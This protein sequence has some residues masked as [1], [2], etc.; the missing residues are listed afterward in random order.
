MSG[1]A[2]SNSQVGLAHATGHALGA[3]FH[4]PHGVAVGISNPYVVQFSSR[5]AADRYSDIACVIGIREES[6]QK[7]TEMLVGSI[8]RLMAHLKTPLSLHEAG[9][10]QSAFDDNVGSLI[11]QTN[12][13]TCTFVNPRVPDAEEIRKLFVC[14]FEGKPANF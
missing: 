1:L 14:M 2:F 9:I 8:K 7:A 4:M 10:S 6:A 12:R 5:D 13:S 11:E 3:I